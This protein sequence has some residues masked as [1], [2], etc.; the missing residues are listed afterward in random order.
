MEPVDVAE[1]LLCLLPFPEPTAIADRIKKR[2]PRLKITYHQFSLKVDWKKEEDLPNG[3][4]TRIL[5]VHRW[6]ISNKL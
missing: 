5:S 4:R 3:K 6:G 2:Y 1:H